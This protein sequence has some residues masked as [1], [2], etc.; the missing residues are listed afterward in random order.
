[1]S[2]NLS[3]YYTNKSQITKKSQRQMAQ[4]QHPISKKLCNNIEVA[5]VL[6][7]VFSGIQFAYNSVGTTEC[8]K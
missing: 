6:M 1:M 2:I 3:T 7:H 8:L 5:Y 4:N